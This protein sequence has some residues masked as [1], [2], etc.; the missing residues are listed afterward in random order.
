MCANGVILQLR[1]FNARFFVRPKALWILAL[2]VL[3]LAGCSTRFMYNQLDWLIIW[4]VNGI[5][6]LTDEQKQTLKESLSDQLYVVRKQEFPEIAAEIRRLASNVEAGEITPGRSEEIYQRM[7]LVM[8]ELILYFVPLTADFLRSMDREQLDELAE[9]FEEMNQDMYDDYSGATSEEREKNRNKSALKTIRRFT[10]RISDPQEAI[11]TDSL[12]KM[13]DA[14]E[15]WINYQRDWQKRF[16][17]LLDADVSEVEFNEQLAQLFVYPRNV[18]S[19]EYRAR[20][21]ANRQIFHQ[22]FSEFLESLTEKQNKHAVAELNNYA[23]LMIKL[24]DDR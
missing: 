5:V 12:A 15:E 10:G 9:S 22:G 4:R 1:T 16:L 7:E 14:S 2:S 3:L 17:Y 19:A 18:H 21:D 8:E 24:S 23:D 20:V 6:E 13:E 11:I